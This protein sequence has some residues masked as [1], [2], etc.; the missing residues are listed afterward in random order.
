MAKATQ[1]TI[2]TTKTVE[3]EEPGV[4]LTL[5]KAEAQALRNVL[6]TSHRNELIESGVSSIFDV[7]YGVTDLAPYRHPFCV[8][9]RANY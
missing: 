3:T 9:R 8:A 1:T 2:K 6:G 4:Q 5:T 7:L